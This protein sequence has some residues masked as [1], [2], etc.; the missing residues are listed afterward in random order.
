ML[1]VRE[2][3]EHTLAASSVVRVYLATQFANAITA[4][5][6]VWL[7]GG[8]VNALGSLMAGGCKAGI[9]ICSKTAKKQAYGLHW[10]DSLTAPRLCKPEPE[11]Y[12]NT[13]SQQA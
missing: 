4:I 1:H 8:F 3:P 6:T 12:S 9:S 7:W 2:E 11:C 13:P 5:S 10:Q